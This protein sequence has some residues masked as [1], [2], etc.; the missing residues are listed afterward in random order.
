MNGPFVPLEI[1][2]TRPMPNRQNNKYMIKAPVKI[3]D[4]EEGEI[5]EDEVVEETVKPVLKADV[6]AVDKRKTS[7]VHR[8]VVLHRLRRMNILAVKRPFEKV[9]PT[10]ASLAEPEIAVKTKP[11]KI[12]SAATV[13]VSRPISEVP[14]PLETVEPIITTEEAQLEK[15]FHDLE[16]LVGEGL[17]K[18]DVQ[19]LER[20]VKIA[21]EPPIE[22]PQKK[23]VVRKKKATEQ[24]TGQDVP[25]DVDLTTAT[26]GRLGEGSVIERL[27]KKGEKVIIRAPNYYMHNRK[28]FI[29]KLNDLFQ[30]YRTEMLRDQEKITCESRSKNGSELLTHQ[31]IVR[32]YLNLYTPFLFNYFYIILIFIQIQLSTGINFLF[33]HFF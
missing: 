33:S 2:E 28:L 4:L 18:E 16:Q 10:V 15:D 26:F 1:L 27:P 13:S 8:E 9:L 31:K 5:D 25:V 6:L 22:K 17:E 24:A 20:A 30:P 32:D 14:V 7:T 19:T 11:F 29:Q 21:T 23:V 12:P 3:V